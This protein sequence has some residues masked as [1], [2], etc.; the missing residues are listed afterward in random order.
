MKDFLAFMLLMAVFFI[1]GMTMG[2]LISRNSPGEYLG[3]CYPNLTCNKDLFCYKGTCLP[4]AA[5]QGGD[6]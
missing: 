1:F 5:C 2:H 3:N 4:N 6:Q